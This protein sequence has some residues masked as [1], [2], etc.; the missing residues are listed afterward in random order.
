MYYNINDI[1]QYF[2]TFELNE[3]D[4]FTEDDVEDFIDSI[5]RNKPNFDYYYGATKLVIAP[6][7]TEY[8]IKIPFMGRYSWEDDEYYPLR[9]TKYGANYCEEEEKLYKMAQEEGLEDMFLPLIRVGYIENYN[10]PVFIQAKAETYYGNENTPKVS[11][12]SANKYRRW[13]SSSVGRSHNADRF[14]SK[15]PEDWQIQ[16]LEFFSFNLRKIDHF[17]KFL[18][19]YTNIIADLHSDNIGYCNGHPVIIDYGGYCEPTVE[20]ENEYE[21]EWTFS[22]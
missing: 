7:D 20:E 18:T 16:V 12:A 3:N 15:L 6:W 14:F 8:V 4:S 5:D 17:I 21:Y 1:M 11:K 22:Y 9:G 10:Y 19:D 13:K 2:E